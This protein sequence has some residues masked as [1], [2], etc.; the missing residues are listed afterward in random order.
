METTPSLQTRK[1]ELLFEINRLL[2]KAQDMDALM[3][4]IIHAVVELTDCAH[5]SILLYEQETNTL[6]FAAS[7]PEHRQ[8]LRLLRVP[9]DRSLT[10]WVFKKNQSAQVENAW[11]DPRIFGAP[12]RE[13]GFP[14][15]T[16]LII[17]LAYRGEPIG[18]LQA[19]DKHLKPNFSQVDLSILE[20]LAYQVAASILGYLLYDEIKRSYDEIHAVEKMKSNFIAIASHEL[21]TPLGLILGHATFINDSIQDPEIKGQL[22]I[23]IKS[24]NRLKAI[25]EDL[26]NVNNFQ[27]GVLNPQHHTILVN[28]LLKKVIGAFQAD[29]AHKQINLSLNVPT[30]ELVIEA[31]EEKII[32][33]MHNLIK[34]AITYTNEGG[35]IWVSAEKLASYVQI[36][37][38]DNG[39]GIPSKDLPH[40]FTRFYQVDS[41]LTRRHGGIGLGLS[42]AKAMIEVHKG[43]IWVESESGKGSKFSILLPTQ[44]TS[45]PLGNTKAF[46]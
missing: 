4:T 36:S 23:I 34:N 10:G 16:A 29:A 42:V 45:T 31:D 40:V 19:V 46:I 22:Q 25:L 43:Q 26:S 14:A 27:T 44:L 21:R 6:K 18:V 24:A 1:L 28:N 9:I 30:E 32:I 11:S 15:H 12:E 33:A 8:R 38:Q 13:F 35:Q 17:P 3:D 7:Q 39:V 5:S 20:T 37:V 2:S 41:H